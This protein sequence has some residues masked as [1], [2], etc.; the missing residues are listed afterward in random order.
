M[1]AKPETGGAALIW[2]PFPDETAVEDAVAILI[3]EGLIACA[4]LVPMRSLYVWQGKREEAREI[5]VLFKTRVDL[6]DRAL[7]R[8]VALHPYEAPAALAW[9]CDAAAPATLAWLGA[10]QGALA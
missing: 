3:D 5:G 1:K 7:E 4:N 9:R 8:L 2:C 10:L 6:V